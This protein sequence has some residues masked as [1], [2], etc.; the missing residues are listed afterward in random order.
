MSAPLRVL[1]VEDDIQMLRYLMSLA[2]DWG[3][4]VDGARSG[5]EALARIRTQCPRV[6]ISDLVM[7]GMNGLDLLKA[8]R[9]FRECVIVFILISGYATVSSAVSAIVEGAEHCLV[10][11][12]DPDQL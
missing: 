10:K 2:A 12:V 5:E 8:L 1:V 9:S 6:V 7:P 3:Y 4:E 11:P